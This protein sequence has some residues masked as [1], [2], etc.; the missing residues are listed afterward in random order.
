M[1]RGEIYLAS[2]PVG[3]TA[4]VNFALCWYSHLQSAMYP[5]FW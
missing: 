2:F 4:T 3:D 1:Q 5:N